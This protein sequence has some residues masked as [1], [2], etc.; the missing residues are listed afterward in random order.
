MSRT[1]CHHSKCLSTVDVCEHAGK[2]LAPSPALPMAESQRT[3][4]AAASVEEKV[5]RGER[6]CPA[7]E[8]E[9]L[10]SYLCKPPKFL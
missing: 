10:L 2:R 4:A 8:R 6:S 5:G 3:T 9:G 1:G 7:L